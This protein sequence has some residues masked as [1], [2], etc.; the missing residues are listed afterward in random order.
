MFLIGLLMY[1]SSFF[2]GASVADEVD[3]PSLIP[4]GRLQRA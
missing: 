3:K 4:G 2:I 1:L